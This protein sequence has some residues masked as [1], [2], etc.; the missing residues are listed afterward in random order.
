[1]AAKHGIRRRYVEGCRRE[2]CTEANRFYKREYRQRRIGGELTRPTTVVKLSQPEPGAPGP[3]RLAPRLRPT[4]WPPRRG[5][6]LLRRRSLWR[7]SWTT[8]RQLTSTR[9]RRGYCARC[10]ISCVRRRRRVVAA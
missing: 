3:S 2:D 4:A 9:Q 6:D 5:P 7:G 8:P 1:M 10:S